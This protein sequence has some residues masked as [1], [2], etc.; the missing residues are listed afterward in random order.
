MPGFD[1]E[2]HTAPLADAIMYVL[3]LHACAIDAEKDH[4]RLISTVA[5]LLSYS[6]AREMPE[7]RVRELERA[8]DAMQY[9]VSAREEARSVGDPYDRRH[10]RDIANGGDSDIRRNVRHNLTLEGNDL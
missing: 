9:V 6:D 2:E 10:F 4:D 3:E 7:N 5:A 8:L 1:A